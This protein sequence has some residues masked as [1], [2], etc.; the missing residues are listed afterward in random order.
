MNKILQGDCLEVLKTLPDNSVDAVIT[1]PPYGLGFMGKEWDTFDRNQ[2]G[3]KGAEGENDL[4]VKKNFNVLPRYNTDGLYDFTAQWATE[5]L[6]V[7][8]PGGYLLSFA[9][10]RTYHKIAMGIEDAGFEIRDMI[11]WVYG[12]GFPKSLNISK[13]I[14]KKPDAY[15]IKEWKNWLEKQ[16]IACGKT[17]KQINDECGFTACSYTKTDN[18]D[19]WSSNFPKNGKW[20][21]MKEVIGI[22]TDEYDW[23]AEDNTEKRGYVEPT[24]GLAGG[25]GNTIGNFTGKQLADNPID[26]KA[27]EWEGWGT[28]LKPSVE[29]LT[30]ARKPLSEKT[31]VENCLKWGTGGINI[32]ACR[33]PLQNNEDISVVRDK[34]KKLDTLQQ[35]WGFKSVS[36]DNKGRYPANLIH[37]GSDEVVRLFPNSKAGKNIEQKGTGGIWNKSS[38]LPCGEQYGDSGSASRFFYCAKASRSERDKGCSSP[39][40]HPTIK[41][42]KLM[43]YLITLVTRKDALVLD[44]FMGS[45]TTGIAC[46]NLTRQFIGIEKDADYIAIAEQRLRGWR[47]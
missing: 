27:K 10:T 33:I 23:V 43:E 44:P 34:V 31:I 28:A 1:D 5:C 13:N 17:R 32:D 15:R 26:D 24:G 6:R 47:G 3:R 12:N 20:E 18:K 9:G 7:L 35:G 22:T 36:R 19:Y 14:D 25:T 29:V 2:F 41:P 8:K 16:I 46:A 21:K 42:I 39:N 11:S 45:G 30:M 38:G 40:T 4:K 37:D